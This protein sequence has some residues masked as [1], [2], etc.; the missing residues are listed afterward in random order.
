MK[1]SEKCS[2]GILTG[3]LCVSTV[4][5]IGN[6]ARMNG[7]KP[8]IAYAVEVGRDIIVYDK[9]AEDATEAGKPDEIAAVDP[10]IFAPDPEPVVE[11]TQTY[12]EPAP[13][14]APE[15]QTYSSRNSFASDGVWYDGNYRYTWYSSNDLYH[16]RTQE[17]N[18]GEDGIYRDSEGYVV[19]ASSDYPQG[20]VIEGT[21]FG[22]VKVYDSGCASGTL[23]V[24]TNF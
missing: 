5:T 24:Y 23:D 14:P 2:L 22:D 20:T 3:L 11:S 16:Y 6:F 21:P 4:C 13:A 15:P 12:Y 18:A 17:W 8:K 9:I 1:L 7:S 19:V 10:A